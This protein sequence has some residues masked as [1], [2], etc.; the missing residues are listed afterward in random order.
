MISFLR[1]FPSHG[2]RWSQRA[3]DKTCG[4]CHWFMF[5]VD[6]VLAEEWVT[7]LPREGGVLQWGEFETIAEILNVLIHATRSQL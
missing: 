3:R 1:S 5:M 6:N 4:K 7:S 2:G